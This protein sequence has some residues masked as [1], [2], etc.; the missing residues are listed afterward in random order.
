V[1]ALE[2]AR[3]GDL[4]FNAPLSIARVQ[5]MIADLRPLTGAS[6]VDL[7]CG[8]GELL[9]R[10]LEHQPT[11]RGVG[12][13]R[14]ET[15]IARAAANARARGLDERLRLQCA[16]ATAW[17]GEADVA[18][19]IG[20]SHAWGGTRETLH[21]MRPRLRP[22]GRL[23][24]GEGIWERPPTPRALAALDAHPGDLTTLPELVELCLESDY[25]LLALST[26]TLNEWDHF[27]SQYCAGRERWLLR[28]PDAPNALEVRTEIDAHR[29]GWLHG[30]REILGFAYLVLGIGSDRA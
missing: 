2:H 25:R 9:L 18:I 22:G 8:W 5:E 26:A 6:I 15:A 12:I 21:A 24:L 23:L 10:L 27:E 3:Y 19:V 4:D 7:G 11:A 17:S 16:D 14:D 28:N 13:D 20:S 1:D 30:Y 29:Q